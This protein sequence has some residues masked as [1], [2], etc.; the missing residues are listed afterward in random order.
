MLRPTAT[1]VTSLDDF[2]LRVVFDN[3]ETKNPRGQWCS[4]LADPAYFR[5]VRA[6]GY[7]VKWADGQDICPDELYYN[8][9][10]VTKK[11]IKA[12]RRAHIHALRLAH[13]FPCYPLAA[14]P[15][16]FCTLRRVLF[17]K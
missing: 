15:T 9:K 2:C 6:N 3:G 11:L 16:F 14:K 1:A 10:T 13:I 4:A 12:S 7:T 5:R 17:A 8:S